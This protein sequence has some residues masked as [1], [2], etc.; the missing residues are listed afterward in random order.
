MDGKIAVLGAGAMGSNIGADLTRA[1]LDIQIFDQWPDHVEA[2]RKNG[3]RVHL[4]G[5]EKTTQVRAH[6]LCDLASLNSEFDVVLLTAKS[7]DT[8]WLTELVK[9]Y[10]KQDGMLVGV[11]NGMNDAE[12]ASIV[13]AQRTVGCVVE[14]SGEVFEPGD[15]LRNTQPYNT[16]FW[17]GELDGSITLRRKIV[18]EIL[19][20]VGRTEVSE[21]ILGAKWTKLI[22]N[23]MTTP[24]SALGIPNQAA[25]Q[26]SGM[27]E[28]SAQVG[29]ESFLVGTALGYAIET[30]FGMTA[31]EMQ[32]S[33]L[34]AAVAVMRQ[35]CKEVGPRGRNHA[36]HDYIK[37]RR[38][39]ISMMNGLVMREG[40]RLGIETPYNT[41]V[42]EVDRR[43]RDGELTMDAGNLAQL[44]AAVEP[45]SA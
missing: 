43:I 8:R 11:Q 19:S 39:E 25:L 36:I 10:L 44:T 34:D 22:A 15:A 38:S 7:Y 24:F 2:M 32:G 33:G 40:A 42:V 5:E 12:I 26:V 23:S 18:R 4:A 29:H 31:E 16:W 6:H 1:G 28:F 3:I 37:G 30:L 45:T 27:I 13:G 20:H 17:I 14:L 35:M 41:A 21:N 9:P